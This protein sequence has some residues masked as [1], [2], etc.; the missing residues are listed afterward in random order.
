[1]KVA[2][3]P[4]RRDMPSVLWLEPFFIKRGVR[5]DAGI[6]DGI[7]YD[8][9]NVG[10]WLDVTTDGA[11][12]PPSSFYTVE[13]N[14][15]GTSSATLIPLTIFNPSDIFD[16]NWKSSSDG[17]SLIYTGTSGIAYQMEL[18]GAMLFQTTLG[19]SYIFDLKAYNQ[20]G[21]V[22]SDMYS[23]TGWGFAGCGTANWSYI[24]LSRTFNWTPNHGDTL[25]LKLKATSGPGTWHAKASLAWF[26][27]MLLSDT[28]LPDGGTNFTDTSGNGI[29]LSVESNTGV[30]SLTSSG[31]SGIRLNSNGNGPIELVTAG[32]GDITLQGDG[33]GEVTIE[34]TGGPQWPYGQGTIPGVGL[35]VRNDGNGEFRIQNNGQGPLTLYSTCNTTVPGI[36]IEDSGSGLLMKSVGGDVAITS[37]AGKITIDTGV[38]TSYVVIPHLPTS[39]PGVHGALWNSSGTLKISP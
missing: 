5:V 36:T 8:F 19:A 26:Q 28:Y 18:S 17:N 38:S 31:S 1:M 27:A 7:R 37:S 9:H 33:Y 10:D 21:T 11:G 3:E 23:P 14:W 2:E 32:D 34:Q 30:L 39:D 16:A 4:L 20:S 25:T 24:P 15:T 13:A 29:G 22:I 6:G 12:T 35:L